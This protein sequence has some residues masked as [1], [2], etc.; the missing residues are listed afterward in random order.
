MLMNVLREL[1]KPLLNALPLL[2]EWDHGHAE[3]L[4]AWEMSA[5]PS[6]G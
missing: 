3:I 1:R 6:S 2:A 5:M 4:T